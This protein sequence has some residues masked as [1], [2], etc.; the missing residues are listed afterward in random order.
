MR[1]YEDLVAEA[2]AADVTGWGFGWLEGRATEERPRWRY[3]RLLAARLAEAESALDIDTGGG[4]VVD[5]A[6]VLPRRLA[7]TESW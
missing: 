3:S 7:V 1:S 4:E 6:P 2:E 5:E